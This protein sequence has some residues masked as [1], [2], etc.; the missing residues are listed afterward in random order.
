MADIR[1]CLT[2]AGRAGHAAWLSVSGGRTRIGYIGLA[3]WRNLGDEAMFAALRGALMPSRLF[4]IMGPRSIERR[5]WSLACRR[6]FTGCVLGGGTMI[7][8]ENAYEYLARALD[9]GL[10]CWALGTGVRNPAFWTQYGPDRLF[11]PDKWVQALKACRFVGVRGPLSTRYLEEAGLPGVEAVGDPVLL[12]ADPALSAPG[13]GRVLGVNWGGSGG[14]VWGRDEEKPRRELA[15]SIRTLVAQGWQVRLFCVWS[16][17]CSAVRRLQAELGLPPSAVTHEHTS[18]ERYMRATAGCSVFVGMKLHAVALAILA[19][20]PSIMIEYRP[21]CRDFMAS[22][23][24]EAACVRVD[25]FEAERLAGEV[26]RKHGSV[27]D[28]ARQMKLQG[29]LRSAAEGIR[30]E[31]LAGQGG[32]RQ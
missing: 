7:F 3:G 23:G 12:L 31:V 17:D 15:E 26:N 19:G 32:R 1:F 10:P 30:A 24:L 28:R 21:K 22:L 4:P 20:V 14:F 13:R 27:V 2:R 9:A 29:R 25:E 5:A 6:A 18:P 11:S 8:S 16:G